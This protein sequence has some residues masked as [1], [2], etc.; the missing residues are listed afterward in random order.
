MT[1]KVHLLLEMLEQD[2][3]YHLEGYQFIRDALM[4]AHEVL[5]MPSNSEEL[6]LNADTGS[7]PSGDESDGT[8]RHLT[9]QQLC[10]AIRRYA[11][12]QYGML[13]K[14]VLNSW[15]IYSTSDFGEMVYN[16]IRIEQMKKSPSDRREDFDLVYEFE[17]AFEPQFE[18]LQRS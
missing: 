7:P 18:P 17:S 12:D 16:L 2:Q 8:E 14:S 10:E 3:R 6:S 1:E 13:A 9:G 5:Q 11:V 4:F 15:G